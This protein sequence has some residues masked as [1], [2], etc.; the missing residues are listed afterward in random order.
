VLAALAIGVGASA[1]PVDEPPP[2]KK[3]RYLVKLGAAV[4]GGAEPKL[5]TGR[6]ILFFLPDTARWAGVAPADGP[7]LTTPQPIA[8]VAV[9]L[10]LAAPAFGD[11]F[12][13]VNCRFYWLKILAFQ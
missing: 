6:L 5:L 10:V 13:Q 3:D 12:G 9:L 1:Q 2:A 7:F 11:V 8:S 4:A